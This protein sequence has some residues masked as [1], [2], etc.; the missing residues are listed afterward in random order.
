MHYLLYVVEFH[1]TSDISFKKFS[2]LSSVFLRLNKSTCYNCWTQPATSPY[3]QTLDTE[4]QWLLTICHTLLHIITSLCTEFIF[5]KFLLSCSPTYILHC[6]CH[7]LPLRF[8][9][10]VWYTPTFSVC[11]QR[12]YIF[13]HLDSFACFTE[14]DFEARRI[15]FK[16]KNSTI[17]SCLM[18]LYQYCYFHV[19]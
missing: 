14:L 9:H 15:F 7:H 10:I 6:D 18:L 2:T 17:T 3:P 16:K 11:E 4:P 8:V 13:Q 1:Y 5:C 12:T 19:S